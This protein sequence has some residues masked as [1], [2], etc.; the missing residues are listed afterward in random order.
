M[1]T[2]NNQPDRSGQNS[3]LGVPAFEELA[4][5]V[6]FA[7]SS[8]EKTSEPEHVSLPTFLNRTSPQ[9]AAAQS[10]SPQPTVS[11]PRLMVAQSQIRD[12]AASIKP[13][14]MRADE[15]DSLPP[16][17]EVLTKF[18][19][20]RAAVGK[21][22]PLPKREPI[23]HRERFSSDPRDDLRLKWVDE[24][25]EWWHFDIEARMVNPETLWIVEKAEEF[26]HKYLKPVWWDR[27]VEGVNDLLSSIYREL[28]R[29]VWSFL[30]APLLNLLPDID[31]PWNFELRGAHV[32]VKQTPFRRIVYDNRIS[33]ELVDRLWADPD[34]FLE[35]GQSLK[36]DDR[37][38]VARVPLRHPETNGWFSTT[39]TGVLKRLNLRGFGHT[40]T[41]M[42]WF[43]R[44]ARAWVYGREMLEAG[45]NTAR[46][47]AM[48]EDR[49]GPL[50]FRSFVLTEHV[51]G[52]TLTRHL[53][54][55]QLSTSELDRLAS[56]FAHI[57]H[58]LGEMRIVHGD[59][60]ACNFLVTPEGQ[61]KLI[62]LD[63]TLRHWFDV[64]F[65]PLRDRDWLRFFKNWKGQPEVAAAFRA[66]VARHFDEQASAQHATVT[67][68]VQLQRAA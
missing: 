43:T 54:N 41:H 64:S 44:A 29:P 55:S 10:P 27:F 26:F 15:A 48:V 9:A 63:G 38:V 39:A 13:H 2:S 62:D 8:S 34:S 7:T 42:L 35:A 30:I 46:P 58:T 22:N 57:W 51:E 47:L 66:A 36:N 3:S 56:Q 25:V 33:Q 52:T 18:Q 21:L 12:G 11:A 37:T 28:I 45:I 60:K 1:T 31:W 32:S 53:Q 19:Q 50:R 23:H 14:F 20:L 24:S 4:M 49:I 16:P 61:L 68:R 59:L 6:S 40:L 67:P 5:H 17:K 65:L